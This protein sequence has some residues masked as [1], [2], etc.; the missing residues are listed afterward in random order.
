MMMSV[1]CPGCRGCCSSNGH[2]E[3]YALYQRF[4]YAIYENPYIIIIKYYVVQHKV[5]QV[6]FFWMM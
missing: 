4:G 6:Y 1:P 5:L 3:K 2:V